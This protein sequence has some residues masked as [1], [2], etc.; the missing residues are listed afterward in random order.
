MVD[1]A[2]DQFNM[3]RHK[4]VTVVTGD[5]TIQVHTLPDRYDLVLVD[6]FDDLDLARGVDSRAFIHGLRDRC[7]ENGVVCINTVSHDP[8]SEE[9]CEKVLLHLQRTFHEAEELRLEGVNRMFIAW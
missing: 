1:L 2:R 3:D 5:A 7:A 9:R 8:L 6:L 4:D